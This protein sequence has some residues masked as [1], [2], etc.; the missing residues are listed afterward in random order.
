MLLHYVL[1]KNRKYTKKDFV[2]LPF[3]EWLLFFPSEFLNLWALLSYG[4]F[5]ERCRWPLLRLYKV[6]QWWTVVQLQW[7]I[8]C[9]LVVSESYFSLGNQFAVL[10]GLN[11]SHKQRVRNPRQFAPMDREGVRT[12]DSEH[13]THT[14]RRSTAR[15][16]YSQKTS[17][18]LDT[19][20]SVP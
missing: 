6:L 7:S 12:G 11:I 3:S 17:V 1:I 4:S 16:S 2:F 13:R 9:R 20:P 18:Q 5:R 8:I 19:Q 15:H 14:H 10:F